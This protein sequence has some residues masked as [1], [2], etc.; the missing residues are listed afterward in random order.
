[1]NQSSISNS[2]SINLSASKSRMK[3]KQSF[4]LKLRNR[5]AAVIA[6]TAAITMSSHS[7]HAQNTVDN[8][9]GTTTGN[10]T[11][12]GNWSLNAVPVITND[13]VFPVGAATGVRNFS[14]GNGASVGPS[15]VVGSLDDLSTGT[16]VT[17][18]NVTTSASA[19]TI[20]LGG[21]GN[22]GNSV[23]GTAADLFYVATGGT[24]NITGTGGT[25]ATLGLVLGQSGNFDVA[26][27]ST[28]TSIISDGGNA[29]AITKTGAG[30]LTLSGVNTFSGG[31][32]VGA[33]TVTFGGNAANLGAG[34]IGLGI[35]SGSTNAIL[36]YNT[37]GVNTF[38]NAVNVN[39]T[40]GGTLE[41]LN[42]SGS[43]N[44][45][46]PVTLA[47]NLLLVN[48]NGTTTNTLTLSGNITGTGNITASATTGAPIILTGTNSYIGTTTLTANNLYAENT[49]ATNVDK[50]LSTGTVILNG[51]SLF[52][53]ADGSGNAQTIITGDG[54][55]GNNVTVGGNTTIDVNKLVAANTGNTFVLNNLSIGANTLNVTGGSSYALKFAGTT[56]LTGN[57]T[58]SPSTANLTLTGVIGDGGSGF[59]LTK[60]GAGT[61]SLAGAN[62]Y[63][64]LTTVSAGTLSLAGGTIA[65][66]NVSL[67]SATFQVLND[68]AGSNGTISLGNNVTV[69]GAT[70]TDTINVGN[71]GSGNTG[72]TVAFGALSNGTPAQG[73]AVTINFT[74]ANGYL[75]SFS[76]LAL[77][78]GGGQGTTLN[79]TSTS[80]T[81]LGNVTNQITTNPPTG[82][83]DTLVLSGTSSG[84]AINGV[85][86]DNANY[87]SVGN[88][89]TRV[90]MTG[91]GSWTLGGANT[92]HGPTTV[93]NGTLKLGLTNA[94]PT[95]SALTVSGSGAGVTAILDLAGFDETNSSLSLGGSTATSGAT[96]TNSTGSSTLKL[97]AGATYSATNNPL[98]ATISTTTLD[99]NGA[100]Q[101]FTVGDSTTAPFDLSISSVIQNG[102]LIKA[103]S[104]VLALSGAN[105]YAGGTSVTAGT[106]DFQKTAAKPVAGTTTVSSGATLGLG[107]GGAGFFGAADVNAYLTN[108][109][110]GVSA[111]R[112]LAIDTTAGDFSLG[113]LALPNGLRSIAKLG[114]N[115]LNLGGITRTLGI[116]NLPNATGAV[117]TTNS[118]DASGILGPW[119]TIG[120]G[121]SI[122]YAVANGGS[123][124]ISALPVAS[125]TGLGNAGGG[126]VDIT[127]FIDNTGSKT[128]TANVAANTIENSFAGVTLANGGFS[129]TTNGILDLTGTTFSGAGHMKAGATKELDIINT[130]VTTTIS[131]VIEDSASGPSSLVFAGVGGGTLVLGGTTNTYT[132][133][134]LIT[135]GTISISVE[136]ALGA[137]PVSAV[138]DEITLDNGTLLVTGSGNQVILTANRGIT[139]GTYGGTLNPGSNN[140]SLTVN[141]VITGSGSLTINGSNASG[142]FFTLGGANTYTGDTSIQNSTVLNV[143]TATAF[144]VGGT[145]SVGSSG[146]NLTPNIKIG[147]FT[148]ANAISVTAGGGRN[149]LAVGATSGLSGAIALVGGATNPTLNLGISGNNET[150]NITGGVTGTGNISLG[151]G[152]SAV[153][154]AQI[155]LSGGAINNIGTITNVG[156]V[157]SGTYTISANIGSNVTGVIQNSSAV[158]LVLSGVN[159]YTGATAINSGKL[160]LTGSLTSAV[161]VGNDSATTAIFSGTGTTTGLVT[162]FTNGANVAYLAPGVNVS[163]T[164]TDFGAAGT[165]HL[166]NGLTIG[167][168]TQL[169]Y[170]LGTSQDLIAGSGALSLGTG[171]TVNV[172]DL[173]GLATGTAYT[174]ISGFG[175][176]SGDVSTWTAAGTAP[177]GTTG[178]TFA[179]SGNDVTLKFIGAAATATSYSLAAVAANNNVLVNHATGVTSTITN[180]GTGT[181]DTL[182]YT[183]LSA[184]ATGGTITGAATNGGP[185]A[186]GASGSN[187]GLTYNAGATSGTYAIAVTPTV[188]TA[189]NDTIG[190]S[191]SNSGTTTQAVTVYDAASLSGSG[192]NVANA[193]GTFRAS[194]AVTSESFNGQAGFTAAGGLVGTQIDAGTSTAAATFD[195]TGKLNGTYNTT[196][197]IGFND[198][199]SGSAAIAGGTGDSATGIA[200]SATVT[201]KTN[202]GSATVLAGQS[203]AGYGLTSS[204]FAQ[205]PTTATLLDG[206]AGVGNTGPL[207]DGLDHTVVMAFS[208]GVG[209]EPNDASKLSDVLT[210]TGTNTDKFVLQ[211]TYTGTPAQG[212]PFLAYYSAAYGGYVNAIAGNSSGNMTPFG[213][214]AYG[215]IAGAYDPNNDFVLGDYGFDAANHTA[216]AVLDHNSDYE[217]IPES[218]TWASLAAGFSTLIV[219]QRGR[220]RKS[221]RLS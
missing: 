46:G 58:F 3:Y 105:T 1:M 196:A 4:A 210:L 126:T 156:V 153:T 190:G 34:A 74:G 125:Q 28:I 119:A 173:G 215:E 107:V 113:G 181:A 93:N 6:T 121:A 136:A 94:I 167:N 72:N 37:G 96:V 214:A 54:T 123:T 213:G 178:Y 75:E 193:A 84:N 85:I 35:A 188:G 2:V 206:H 91:T 82:K 138:A 134:T 98:G 147:N 14:V 163:G 201:G 182:D 164:R 62:T 212:T 172:A 185:L 48:T 31:F 80:V 83:F 184:S 92:Y 165:L 109:L 162:T 208:N 124:P 59:T 73:N 45:S 79:P 135:N 127:N 118:N 108:T 43:V 116:L 68:G 95:A 9:T 57:A 56:T 99:L 112:N 141:G 106:L 194:A 30:T 209:G 191:A 97:T 33:G 25:G 161:T 55:T 100:A 87:T 67:G 117:T 104:G 158:P 15:L 144:G 219:W 110:S 207:S 7:A 192:L 114:A 166:N 186:L 102:S 197:T 198:V 151:S 81:I 221:V 142:R 175:S 29:F 20:T 176:H 47:N 64:G 63:S 220:R 42:S 180:T 60:T 5:V 18:Q 130:N 159:T 120:T 132:G 61:L 89:D 145:V 24:F 16:T 19:V 179:L 26:G 152:S 39:A 22:L 86:A 76:S 154:G 50:A 150:F 77:T 169:D 90:T 140:A 174:L 211:L 133:K 41:I 143:N 137:T 12:P 122:S 53:K 40:S 65:N 187:S 183:G 49:G 199:T 32:T 131:S 66:S 203:Y 27:T 101:T 13:A 17:I 44:F 38:T 103:G 155:N 70:T 129:V 11:T 168:G 149:F 202:N 148:V 189:T 204:G 200:L 195:S 23:S 217:V 171:V 115:T 160:R 170:D 218:S 51:G 21:A 69:N 52:L 128:F 157:T 10:V 36:Q 216:W 146:S 205:S 177:A 78:G 139:L 88:G 71:N 111:S 8:Y